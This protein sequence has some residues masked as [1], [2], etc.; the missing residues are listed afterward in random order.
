MENNKIQFTKQEDVGNTTPLTYKSYISLYGQPFKHFIMIAELIDNSI[1]SF[2]NNF[3]NEEWTKPLEIE[4]EFNFKGELTNPKDNALGFKAVYGSYIKFKDNGYGMSKQKL[5]EAMIL[6]NNN[7]EI[8]DKNVW[9]RGMKQCAYFFGQ[10]LTVSTS[11]G[12]ES[13]EVKQIYT[14]PSISLNSPYKIEPYELEANEQGTTILIE[15]IYDERIF[16]KDV[17]KGIKNSLQWRYVNY[18]RNKKLIVHYT[19]VGFNGEEAEGFFEEVEEAKMILDKE[20]KKKVKDRTVEDIKEELNNNFKNLINKK[21]TL[22]IDEKIANDVFNK[23]EQKFIGSLAGDNETVF[24]SEVKFKLPHIVTGEEQ[25][26]S[27]KFWALPK[28]KQTKDKDAGIRFYEGERAIT[29]ISIKDKDVGPWMGWVENSDKSWRT[30]KKF[31]GEID[32]K[33][34]GA[35]PSVDKSMFSLP[36]VIL[37]KISKNVW[38]VYKVFEIFIRLIIKKVEIK[39]EAEEVELNLEEI[40][41]ST[42]EHSPKK[43]VEIDLDKSRPKEK[44]LHFVYSNEE[45]KWGVDL[46]FDYMPNPPHILYPIK[47]ANED[48]NFKVVVYRNHKFWKFIKSS[49]KD[50]ENL[51][52]RSVI[53]PILHLIVKSSIKMVDPTLHVEKMNETAKEQTTRAIKGDDFIG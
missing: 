11:D 1:S 40:R 47:S 22:K 51:Y 38:T 53:L 49:V 18:I 43:Q 32:L 19:Y 44:T 10:D 35:K 37:N 29:H 24:E 13:N 25:T 4:I 23:L 20:T 9:G 52:I 15:N 46:S 26:I 48:T 27:F 17:L 16:S 5:K 34:I 12:N 50:D 8:S 30:D 28:G 45:I 2:E 31:A 42:L 33:I 21:N 14:D 6:D 39:A 41:L 7:T 36:E 3:S